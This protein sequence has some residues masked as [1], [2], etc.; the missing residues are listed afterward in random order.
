M[1]A[2]I[3]VSQ[4]PGGLGTVKD[5]DLLAKVPMPIGR[6][7]GVNFDDI[8]QDSGFLVNWIPTAIAGGVTVS[9]PLSAA[10]VI[11]QV[12]GGAGLDGNEYNATD[13][14]AAVDV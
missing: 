3:I 8:D 1:S 6:F 7:A 11:R 5:N 2:N 13:G 10:G 9:R 12:T 4:F 14:G